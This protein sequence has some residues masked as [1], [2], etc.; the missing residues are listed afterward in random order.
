MLNKKYRVN[1][2]QG[3]NFMDD[4]RSEPM[5]LNSLRS[6]FWGLGDCRT[7]KYSQFTSDYIQEMW[8]VE[9]ELVTS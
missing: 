5:T 6:R 1:D 7:E 9:F 2:L 8:Q 4:T 3:S